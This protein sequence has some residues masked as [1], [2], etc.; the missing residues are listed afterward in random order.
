MNKISGRNIR[1][2]KFF[3][4]VVGVKIRFVNKIQNKYLPVYILQHI[5]HS[6]S[7]QN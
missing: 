7:E 6:P 3:N 4:I 1:F 2:I 5:T